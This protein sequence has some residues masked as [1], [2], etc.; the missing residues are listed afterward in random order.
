MIIISRKEKIMDKYI[1]PYE[2][3]EEMLELTSEIMESLGSLNSVNDLDKLP[4]LRRVSRIKSIHS[5]L[6]IE[7]NTLSIEQVTDVINGKKVIGPQDDIIA[8]KNA[9]AAYKALDDV[10]PFSVSDLLKI[11]SIM[12]NGLVEEA[13]LLRTSQ[14]GVYN[15]K[16]NVIHIAPPCNLVPE[17]IQQL[18]EW[19]STSKT[20]MLIKSSVF[21]YEFEFIHPFRDGNG[22]MGRLWQTALLASWKPIFAWIPIESIIKDN[23]EAYYEAIRISTSEGKSNAFIIFMLKIINQA[24]KDIASDSRKHYQHISNQITALLSVIESYPM[25]TQEIMDKL[26]LK[27][28]D[29]FRNNYIKPALEAGLIGMTQPDKPTSKNQRYYRL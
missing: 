23:Q 22:R 16:G 4:R 20:Q 27:S 13:G 12:M 8:V 28:R 18:F 29:G 5:S 17:L 7:N 6:A 21:H 1:P 2:I 24:I 26:G 11:H 10:N 14:V 15:E 3:T 25:S 9:F 19:T